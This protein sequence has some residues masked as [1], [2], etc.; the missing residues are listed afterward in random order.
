[1][2]FILKVDLFNNMNYA[3]FAAGH[4]GELMVITKGTE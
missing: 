1:M 4:Q 2:I 3:L